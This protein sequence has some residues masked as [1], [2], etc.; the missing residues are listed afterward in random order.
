[1]YKPMAFIQLE[2]KFLTNKWIYLAEDFEAESVVDAGSASIHR[3]PWCW[4]VTLRE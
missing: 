2:R 3:S 4:T 1:M